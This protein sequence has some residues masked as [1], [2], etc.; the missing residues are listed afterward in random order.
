MPRLP[1]M[2]DGG[3]SW[4]WL[5]HPPAPRPLPCCPPLNPCSAPGRQF[6]LELLQSLLQKEHNLNLTGSYYSPLL[7]TLTYTVP[8]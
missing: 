3:V 6:G 4:T 5:L 7:G 8:R 2:G 1:G